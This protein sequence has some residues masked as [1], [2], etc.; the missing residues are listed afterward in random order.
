MNVTLE[1][2]DLVNFTTLLSN[3]CIIMIGSLFLILSDECVGI[4]KL[5]GIGMASVYNPVQ[6]IFCQDILLLLG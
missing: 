3:S 1:W 5:W 6:L 4:F 2:I